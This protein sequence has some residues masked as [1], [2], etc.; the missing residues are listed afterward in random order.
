MFKSFQNREEFIALLMNSDATF[1]YEDSMKE[2]LIAYGAIFRT[3]T[4][5]NYFK[6]EI[7]ENRIK[8]VQTISKCSDFMFL[9]KKIFL[10]FN[11]F[12]YKYFGENSPSF[13]EYN[14]LGEVRSK[15]YLSGTENSYSFHK[16]IY[17]KNTVKESFH[18][19]RN[20]MRNLMAY[21]TEYNQDGSVQEAYYHL[22]INDEYPKMTKTTFTFLSEILPRI[23]Y[24]SED[25]I[26]NLSESLQP[27]EIELIKMVLI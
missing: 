19:T 13:Y 26:I 17:F 6:L 27:H 9:S 25:Q 7:E 14:E 3:Q 23:T 1:I 20:S 5:A 4:T 16:T 12:S 21:Y 2:D 22:L 11:E 18:V 10:V 15:Q 24:F 8:I